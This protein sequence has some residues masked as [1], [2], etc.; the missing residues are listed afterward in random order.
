MIRH[1]RLLMVVLLLGS[2]GAAQAAGAASTSETGSTAP[3]I[4]LRDDQGENQVEAEDAE[5]EEVEGEECAGEAFEFG[6]EDAEEE[7]EAEDGEEC[8]EEDASDDV[9]APAAC[10]IREAESSVATLP[11]SDQLRLTIK[12]KTYSPTPATIGLKLLDRKGSRRLE[13]ANRHLGAGGVLHLD[14]KITG[15]LLE[16]TEK[17]HGLDVSLRA[18]GTPHFC[19]ELL[20][21]ELLP[22]GGAQP[23][24]AGVSFDD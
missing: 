21:Q 19:G 2:L 10:L 9:S 18:P 13:H 15:S 1:L 22:S 5:E 4:A 11:G 24:A 7:F 16:R 23:A 17:A 3:R 6:G 12:Y 20:E 14:T 8:G